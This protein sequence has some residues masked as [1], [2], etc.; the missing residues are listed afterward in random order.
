MVSPSKLPVTSLAYILKGMDRTNGMFKICLLNNPR[1]IVT[2]KTLY[3]LSVKSTLVLAVL[4]SPH[5]LLYEGESIIIRNVC[6][7]FIETR[8]EIL[9]LHNF[10][11]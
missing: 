4:Y 2:T 5:S 6:F 9:Q 7:V 10:S 8:V 1:L 3:T 11:T